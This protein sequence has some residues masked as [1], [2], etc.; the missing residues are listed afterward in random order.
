MTPMREA[1][2][3]ASS[4][5]CVTTMK[6][7]PS[8]SWMLMSSNCV[9]S[10][11]FLSSA[12]SGSSSSSSLGRFT[13]ERASATRCRWPPE[14]WCGLRTANVASFTISSMSVTRVAISGRDSPFPAR[15]RTRCSS[16]PSCAGT[17]RT[18]G[19]SCSRA[20]RRAECRPCPG[21]RGRSRRNS[22]SSKPA[23]MRS[24]VDLPQPE[25][26]SRQK[27]SPL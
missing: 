22:V 27:I 13:S 15:G 9:A 25:P 10:R 11:S 21:R 4:W 2:V 16:R 20:A 5:S 1:S 3:M 6:V 26:P 8:C 12:P 19:T 18:T 24:S 23:I 14:S 7:T 17:A